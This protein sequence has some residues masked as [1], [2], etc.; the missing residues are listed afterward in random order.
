MREVG[1]FRE[2][3]HFFSFLIVRCSSSWLTHRVYRQSFL[4]EEQNI[5][6]R[7]C[8]LKGLCTVLPR[9]RWTPSG[10]VDL[11]LHCC[12]A[13]ESARDVKNPLAKVISGW[14]I[15]S[16]F[17]FLSRKERTYMVGRA[18][19]IWRC[20]PR[21]ILCAS[22]FQGLLRKIWPSREISFQSP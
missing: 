11:A 8:P 16:G 13:F 9:R 17:G 15:F 22:F 2:E 18:V 19:I 21:S 7:C 10:L 1:V 4:G 14:L 12:P 3:V 6:P 5:M 20:A